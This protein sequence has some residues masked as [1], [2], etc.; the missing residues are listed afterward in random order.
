MKRFVPL[1]YKY[2][3]KKAPSSLT[4]LDIVVFALLI[5]F[6]VVVFLSAFLAG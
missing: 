5:G 4:T 2:H 3:P 1:P 6:M